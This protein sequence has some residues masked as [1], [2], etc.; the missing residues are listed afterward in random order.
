LQESA[1]ICL[2]KIFIISTREKTRQLAETVVDSGP[3]REVVFIS[4]SFQKLQH[5][6]CRRMA[7][8]DLYRTV[9]IIIIKTKG[10]PAQANVATF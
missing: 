1:P 4:E 2:E 5:L 10:T 7:R 3:D 8:L 6:N 9:I